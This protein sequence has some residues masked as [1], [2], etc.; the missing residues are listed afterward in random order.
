MFDII[1]KEGLIIDPSQGISGK[2]SVAIQ[3]GKIRAVGEKFPEGEA[4]K[5]YDMRGKIIAP[6][7]IDIHCHPV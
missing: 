1:L 5:V 2:G 4:K 6:G 7:L 3:D